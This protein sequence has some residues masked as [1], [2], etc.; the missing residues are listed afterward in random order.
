MHVSIIVIGDEVLLGQVI[1]TNSGTLSRM[2][3]PHGWH[4]DRVY[5]IADKED[6]IIRALDSALSLSDVVLTTGGLGPTNDDITK[7]TLCRYFGGKLVLDPVT[8]RNVKDVVARRG[9]K[10]NQLTA[11]QAYVPDNCTVIQNRVGT[12]P[13]MWWE[14]NDKVVVSMPGVP[15]ET[16]QMFE[17]EVLPR[18][19]RRYPTDYH[20]GHRNV[21][22][23]W[24]TESE[25]AHLLADFEAHIP[26]ELHLA[27]LPKPGLLRL[28]LDGVGLDASAVERLLDEGVNRIIKAVGSDHVL[29]VNDSTIGEI[30]KERFAGTGLSI[31][32]A[33]SCTGGNIAHT[34]TA[35]AG[36]SEYFKGSV[37]SYANSVKT[38]VLG[39]DPALIASHGAVSEPVAATMA[40]GVRRI[41]G[42]DYAVSTSGIAGPGGGTPTKPVGTVCIAV[43]GPNGTVSMTKHLPGSRDRV[44]DRATTEALLAVLGKMDKTPDISKPYADC[45]AGA[46][47]PDY[48]R[49]PKSESPELTMLSL[50]SGCGGMDL[51]FEGGFICH[52]L[53]VPD[54]SP[55]IETSINDNWVLLK[56][57]RFTTIFANDILP[58]ARTAWNNYMGRFNKDPQIYHSQSIVELVKL[59]WQGVDVF[60][61]DVDIV[62][63]GFP[64][65][66]FSLAGKRRGFESGKMHDGSARDCDMPTEESRGKLYYWMKQVID[67][68]KPKIFIAENVKGLVSLGEV[69][70]IIQHDFSR[71]DDNG[72]I[73][74]DPQVLHAGDYG[75]PE[76][77]ER[78]IFIGIRKSSLNPEARRVFAAGGKLPEMYNPYPRPT[79]SRSLQAD[80]SG[81]R[82]AVTCR[83][84]FEELKE[85]D[86]SSDSSQRYYSHAKY[87]GKHCQGQS[88]IPLDGLGPT[89]RSE[90]H[91]NI[92]YR[93]LSHA[94]GGGNHAEL[95]AGMEERRL[96]P[97]E[98]AMIQTFP[99]DYPFV[100]PSKA[101]KQFELSASGA[102]KVIG[103]AVPPLL[104]YNIARR[105]GEVWDLY[106][107][108]SE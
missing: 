42:A 99:P 51:G 20:Y 50:F 23:G 100:T 60:P 14:H 90:H 105:L 106:F 63:G 94:H 36:S 27:Y 96:T 66:D 46:T 89:I 6:E 34:I 79:H 4:V 77:R 15:F 18:L 37:V 84:V 35:V 85:P 33:E 65:Q 67:I 47:L 16:R 103:N 56:K 59:H 8:L 31:V 75:V 2:L 78:V 53:S 9:I 101:T 41:L 108:G 11:N 104:A 25:C 19:L 48:E 72:Y 30:V 1:D 97:R 74:L 95:A 64:C 70:D 93:R 71:A 13:L 76:A 21:M 24:R 58:E 61:K 55:W 69:K 92:E 54:Q 102:Y 40:E 28:R 107:K 57:N 32:T 44:I 43:A 83:D 91:G 10:L 82:R 86:E 88:E 81:L 45:L 73:V 3:D 87:M 22:V 26:P 68:V 7:G 39:V 98:C 80:A 17:S 49:M 29:S 62:T 38:G 12:A 52:K 5:T